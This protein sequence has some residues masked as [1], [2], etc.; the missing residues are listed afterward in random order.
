MR[1]IRELDHEDQHIT[2]RQ[3]GRVIVVT[4]DR[5]TIARSVT[6]QIEAALGGKGEP[7]PERA[8]GFQMED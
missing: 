6:R 1:I 3:I 7:Q 4:T 2:I 5:T 8:I